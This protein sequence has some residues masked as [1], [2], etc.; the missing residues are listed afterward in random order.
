V[1]FDGP[2]VAAVLRSAAASHPDR[3]AVIWQQERISY[4]DLDDRADAAAAALQ[5][6]GVGR[7]D[8]VAVLL[9]NVPAFVEAYFGILRAGAAVVPLTL[10]LAADE[11]AHALGDSG[12]R[13]VVVAGAVADEI[14]DVAVELDVEVLVAGSVHVPPGTTRWAEA[15]E[16]AGEPEEVTCAPDDLGA[17]VYTSGTTGRPKGA[18]LTRGNLAANQQQS[19]AGRFKVSAADTVL[20]V[21]PLSHIYALNVGLGACVRTGAGIVL[22]ERFDPTT[23]LDAIEEHGVTIVLGA[24]PMYIAWN[25]TPGLADRDLSSLRLAVSGSSALWVETLERFRELTGLTIEEGYG[26]TEASPSVTSNS[27]APHPRPGTVGVPLPDVE[28]RLVDEAGDDVVAGDPGEVLVRGP[29][30]FAGYFNDPDATRAVLHDGWLATGDVGVRDD[31]GY[32]RLVDRNRDVVI[33]NGFNV[34]PREVERV[35]EDHD[36]VADCAVVGVAHPYSGEAVKAFVVADGDVTEDELATFC[37]SR[38]A[39]YKCPEV[40]AFVDAVPRTLSGKLRR[41]ALRGD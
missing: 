1:T 24:P 16:Q 8:R 4:A 21:L 22:Q 10:G 17:L 26:L 41:T 20:L 33:V 38:L 9:G 13:L 18:M 19:L 25:Q 32:L 31:D 35:L 34:Y 29:N 40:V 6:R 23:A 2:D 37:R 28:L 11:V 7:G 12:A 39:R 14:A 3:I 30:V 36:A 27:N 5:Q 15:L